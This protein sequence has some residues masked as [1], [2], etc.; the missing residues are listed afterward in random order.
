[1]DEL[2]Y[3]GLC[4]ITAGAEPSSLP[5]DKTQD[6]HHPKVSYQENPSACQPRQEW[7]DRA[8]TE[9]HNKQ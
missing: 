2:I 1:M 9:D 4:F 7:S 6:H 3:A 5:I 8:I